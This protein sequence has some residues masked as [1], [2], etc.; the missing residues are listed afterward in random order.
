MSEHTMTLVCARTNTK[1][2]RCIRFFSVD[3]VNHCALYFD[4]D[5]SVMYSY[6]RE[7]RHN[8]LSGRFGTE[9]FGAMAR[10]KKMLY[11]TITFPISQEE[12]DT[13]FR[14]FKENK[15]RRYKIAALL[16]MKFKRY[17]KDEK[18]FVCSTFAAYVLNQVLDLDQPYYTY[19]PVGLRDEMKR[20]RP[21]NA[22]RF[23][24]TKDNSFS[25]V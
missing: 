9:S 5:P 14:I 1:V 2:G 8:I 22:R 19:T 3:D 25:P 7:H 15:G 21:Q 13:I 6:R 18:S 11:D 12:Y 24:W 23:F 17:Y 4:G 16:L 10:G 20:K